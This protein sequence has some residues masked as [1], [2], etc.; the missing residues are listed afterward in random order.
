MITESLKKIMEGTGMEILPIILMGAFIFCTLINFIIDK[1]SLSEKIANKEKTNVNIVTV[2]DVLK[3]NSIAPAILFSIFPAMFL[4]LTIVDCKLGDE[5]LQIIMKENVA[6]IANSMLMITSIA[7]MISLSINIF[8]KKYFLFSKS[9]VLNIYNFRFWI[10]LTLF[11]CMTSYICYIFMQTGKI[12]NVFIVVIFLLFQCLIMYNIIA[13][14]MIFFISMRTVF[15]QKNKE[16]KILS[17]LY[18][19]LW[20]RWLDVECFAETKKW[21]ERA[22]YYNLTYLLNKYLK[23]AK[24]IRI[25]KVNYV[26]Y[27]SN[28]ERNLEYYYK[29][30]VRNF[31][32]KLMILFEIMS[33]IANYV[34]YKS[35]LNWTMLINII[36]GVIF[37]IFLYLL[38]IK[39]FKK[40]CV[41]LR[42][43]YHGYVI[44]WSEEKKKEKFIPIVALR[45]KRKYEKYIEAMNSLIAF[46]HIELEIGLQDEMLSKSIAIMEQ[47]YAKPNNNSLPLYFP[48]FFFGYLAFLKNKELIDIK[49]IYNNMKMDKN[50]REML[51]RFMNSQEKYM[52][53]NL[54]NFLNNEKMVAEY[55][56]WLE[57]IK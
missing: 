5:Q 2:E 1:F 37:Y 39:Y 19:I 31:W 53:E 47:E 10:A 17:L 33:I 35:L 25:S 41:A 56:L 29:K 48:V 4:L 3:K 24:R 12:E 26:K 55:L 16:Q 38:D 18:K 32:I 34:H 28:I 57:N 51:K 44:K 36:V 52:K 23:N 54:D 30:Y 27:I 21:N 7:V 6:D 15:S 13:V 50:N 11:S 42:I 43:D 14:C 45:I 20:I 49:K 22:I 8:N 40:V 46:L 9:T